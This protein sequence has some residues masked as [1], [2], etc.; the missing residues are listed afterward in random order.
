M[1][2]RKRKPKRKR[3]QG[4][5]RT[6][7]REAKPAPTSDRIP[8]SSPAKDLL[9]GHKWKRGAEETEATKREMRRATTKGH[10]NIFRARARRKAGIERSEIAPSRRKHRAGIPSL[11]AI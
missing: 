9:H 8:G 5:D 4:T 11:R 6:C 7:E 1:H 3:R 2:L 10:C